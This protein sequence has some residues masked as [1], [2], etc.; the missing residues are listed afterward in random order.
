VSTIL[1]VSAGITV[2]AAGLAALLGAGAAAGLTITREAFERRRKE[3]AAGW[4]LHE[5]LWWMQ[6]GI[7]RAL[8]DVPAAATRLMD[9]D[10]PGRVARETTR[11]Y[12]GRWWY[13]DELPQPRTDAAALGII[14][15]AVTRSRYRSPVWCAQD[16]VTGDP[17]RWQWIS[18]T[19]TRVEQLRGEAKRARAAGGSAASDR[20]RVE[21]C[22][23]EPERLLETYLRL[24]VARRALEPL[25]NHYVPR[26]GG[27]LAAGV[28]AT[29]ELGELGLRGT[30]A[31]INV[32]DRL[33]GRRL[34]PTGKAPPFGAGADAATWAAAALRHP[35]GE[36]EPQPY[37]WVQVETPAV[38]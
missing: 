28:P 7:A 14:A 31:A 12:R 29:E 8:T 32:D 38:T 21:L 1:A 11:A 23:D 4:I 16:R 13:A 30:L 10:S 20:K 26:D 34:Y 27:W 6:S 35:P 5:D 22:R 19:L 17:L 2:L 36:L 37:P 24:E 3:E 15:L 18:L 25:I 33:L 9:F